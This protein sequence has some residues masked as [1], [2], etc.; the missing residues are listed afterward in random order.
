MD[1]LSNKL[2]RWVLSFH[3]FNGILLYALVLLHPAFYMLFLYKLKGVL[4]PFYIYSDL[5]VLC[6]GNLEH[7][8]NLGRVAFWLITAGIIAAIFRSSGSFLRKNWRKFHILNYLAF[9][10]VSAHA[11]T[12]GTDSRSPLFL[13]YFI[14]LQI[15]VIG[16]IFKKLKTSNPIEGIKKILCL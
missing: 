4:N 1:K 8:Y 12:I 10:F 6:Q 3:I 5:C 15:V 14:L 16:S 7:F 9:L 11:I 2:G 13:I